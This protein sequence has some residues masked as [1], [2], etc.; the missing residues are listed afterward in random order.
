MTFPTGLSCGF[1][2]VEQFARL[3]E[4]IAV[5]T[6]SVRM[7]L[8]SNISK[9]LSFKPRIYLLEGGQLAAYSLG[10]GQMSEVAALPRKGA[11][12]QGLSARRLVCSLKADASLVFFLATSPAGLL[13]S[14]FIANHRFQKHHV[15]GKI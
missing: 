6:D 11:S 13:C 12:G 5:S 8:C 4:R 15:L 7:S 2:L 9:R 1:G 3:F 14:F 10:T